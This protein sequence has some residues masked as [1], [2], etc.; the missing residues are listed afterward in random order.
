LKKLLNVQE[1][2][3][4]I[5]YMTYADLH[6]HYESINLCQ[7]TQDLTKNY[8][9]AYQYHGSWNEAAGGYRRKSNH[10]IEIDVTQETD[11]Y[12]TFVK[13]SA[14]NT[15]GDT[16]NRLYGIVT[17]VSDSS[18]LE[19]S[20]Q[21]IIQE[22]VGNAQIVKLLM[23]VTLKP[24]K[25][26]I[27]PCL[28]SPKYRGK[29]IVQWKSTKELANVQFVS[30]NKVSSQSEKGLWT[31][32]TVTNTVELVLK[33]SELEEA[34]SILVIDS[35]VYVVAD[36]IYLLDETSKKLIKV[37]N[38]DGWSE[39]KATVLG[40]KIYM[41]SQI[42]GKVVCWDPKTQSSTV[43]TNEN[44]KNG[45]FCTVKEDKQEY[46]YVF[47][48]YIYR[49]D[50]VNNTYVFVS[51]QAGW[52]NSTF[53]SVIDRNIFIIDSGSGRFNR[54]NID[55]KEYVQ[56]AKG[57]WID[58][59]PLVATG[60]QL[61]AFGKDI[62]RIDSNGNYEKLSASINNSITSAAYDLKRSIVWC[63]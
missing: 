41:I 53:A 43:V 14:F 19:Y 56:F 24:G 29:F 54:W 16:V 51:K 47:C 37:S 63:V 52:N 57:N 23:Q 26:R 11:L 17:T 49:Y 59:R 31:L 50:V 21:E 36:F 60:N 9:Y 62:Y 15:Y 20:Q 46:L 42:S 30:M 35:N 4:G 18:E 8:P 27:V 3:D 13:K 61:L 40:G 2:N 12:I 1:R 6:T 32:N 58:Y 10:Y 38:Q 55:S 22:T 48:K 33:S 25:Y 45:S 28:E 44:W 7:V 39:Y 34:S 5:F